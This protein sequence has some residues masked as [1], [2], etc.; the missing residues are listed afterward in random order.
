MIQEVNLKMLCTKLLLWP[1]CHGLDELRKRHCHEIYILF[2][3]IDKTSVYLYFVL[4]ISSQEI[5]LCVT[6]SHNMGHI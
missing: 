6:N 1:F 2:Q 4:A 5:P 3:Q